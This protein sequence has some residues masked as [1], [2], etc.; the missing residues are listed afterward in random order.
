MSVQQSSRIPKITL[1]S[2]SAVIDC[3]WAHCFV[4]DE[5]GNW[6]SVLLGVFEAE[7]WARAVCVRLQTLKTPPLSSNARCFAFNVLLT[8][9]MKVNLE[10]IT[11]FWGKHLPWINSLHCNI[12]R[13]I[14]MNVWTFS[15]F[16]KY[17]QHMDYISCFRRDLPWNMSNIRPMSDKQNLINDITKI[18]SYDS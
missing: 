4:V 9:I 8:D 11:A 15:S 14:C 7:I 1:R 18:I 17:N 16:H 10:Q 3:V 12:S 6:L 13:D 5:H 2:S